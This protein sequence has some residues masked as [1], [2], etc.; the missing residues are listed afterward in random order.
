MPRELHGFRGLDVFR[1]YT[2][3]RFVMCPRLATHT[4]VCQ[5]DEPRLY[6]GL[7]ANADAR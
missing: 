7:W 2:V 3:L 5:L 4:L 6:P 1:T